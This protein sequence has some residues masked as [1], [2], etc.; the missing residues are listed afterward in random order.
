MPETFLSVMIEK[1]EVLVHPFVIG[2][3]AVG[4][5]RQRGL[6]LEALYRLPQADT[7]YHGEVL[8]FISDHQ[9][10]GSGIGCIDTHLLVA[11]QLTG[12]TVLWTRDKRL[13]AAAQRLNL[14][15]SESKAS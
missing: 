6:F 4:S 10:F 8:Q 15:W 12:D 13:L 1:G 5:L 3:V 11:A 2:E 7:A 9:L 14:A